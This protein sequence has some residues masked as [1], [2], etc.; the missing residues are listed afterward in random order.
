MPNETA[1]N[2]DPLSAVSLA[3]EAAALRTRAI[4]QAEQEYKDASQAVTDALK[5][6]ND[7]KTAYSKAKTARIEKRNDLRTTKGSKPASKRT[8]LRAVTQTQSEPV[9]N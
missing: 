4:E 7:A 1:P 3:A 9:A 8:P 5:A 2:T 6:L